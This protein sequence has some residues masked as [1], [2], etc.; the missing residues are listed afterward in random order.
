VSH[1]QEC[2]ELYIGDSHVTDAQFRAMILDAAARDAMDDAYESR[3]VAERIE[4]YS[5]R[6]GIASRFGLFRLPADLKPGELKRIRQGDP[7]PESHRGFV[8]VASGAG[9]VT[10]CDIEPLA[11]REQ[12][13]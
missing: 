7:L 13:E 3:D 2:I 12:G 1:V 11:R 9:Y 8:K 6:V 4:R 5:V 10:G